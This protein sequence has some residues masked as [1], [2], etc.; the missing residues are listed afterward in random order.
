MKTRAKMY[1]GQYRAVEEALE[2]WKVDHEE[3][4]GV[5]DLEELIPFLASITP[6]VLELVG[7]FWDRGFSGAIGDPDAMG[8]VVLDALE[9]GV[10]AW[11]AAQGGVRECTAAGYVVEGTD[12]IPAAL[13]EIT[14][15]RDDFA[16]RWPF[17]R[18]EDVE[19][20]AREIAAGR[21]VTGEEILRELHRQGG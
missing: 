4:M 9:A 5:C 12:K 18:K 15:A 14:A 19:R 6:P 21:F 1:R 16:R 17:S 13:A 8:Q 11:S 10:E 3:A 7:Y 20:G 2:S